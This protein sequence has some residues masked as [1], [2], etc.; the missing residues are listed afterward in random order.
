M[1]DT[2]TLEDLANRLTQVLPPGLQGLRTELQDN[3]RAILQANLDRLDL[4]SR[5]RFDTQVA[6]LR[7][8]QEML[9][10]L[11]G[12]VAELEAGSTQQPTKLR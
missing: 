7:R 3:F 6:L 5:E 1:M 11:E 12:R 9:S 8:T 2:T 4:V 10:A